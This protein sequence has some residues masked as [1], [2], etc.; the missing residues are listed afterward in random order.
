MSQEPGLNAG[1]NLAPA[2]RL[3]RTVLAAMSR[4]SLRYLGA[5]GLCGLLVLMLFAI[6]G[7]IIWQGMGIAGINHPV[8]W[9]VFITNFVFWVGIAHSGTLISAVL[10]LFRA[11]F[12]TS[13]NRAAEA[14]TLIALSVAGLFPLI[15]LGRVW[16]FYY[17]LP[18]PS[19]RLIWPNFRSPLVWDVF[20]VTTYML[21]S[22]A[23]FY[24]GLLPDLAILRRRL[25]GWR[26][27]VY[28]WLSLGWSG[29]LDEWRHYNRV[30][31]FLAAF[32]TPLV[33]SVHSI[34]SWD[35]AVSIVPGWHTTIFAPYFVAGAIL[36]GSA[37]VFTL[38]IPMR[39]I[40]GLE[41]YIQV[42]HFEALAKILLFT[43]LIVSYSYICET[44]LAWYHG[45]LF[46]MEQFRYRSFGD[47]WFLYWIMILCNSLLPLTLWRKSWRRNLRWLFILSLL[48]NVGMWLERFVIIVN[49]LAREYSPY[50]WGTYQVSLAELGITLGSFG[51]FFAMFLLF[52]KLLPVLSMTEIKER[53]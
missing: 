32:A 13:F 12:R 49:S 9:G 48:V 16:I 41:A 7:V 37:M 15:H 38:T 43:S 44:A 35:F 11:R 21:V 1:P 33:A 14:M 25:Q 50:A 46:E 8:S 18:Y 36:S 27:R 31:L 30:Y 10:Y 39:R 51:L 29:S 22:A 34:V 17:L 40:L 6:W 19:E 20:A 23:F 5:L 3:E 53:L 26:S 28:G 52:C 4:P 24:I 42:D 2:E 45:N 47:Y